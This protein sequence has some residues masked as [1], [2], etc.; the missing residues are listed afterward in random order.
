[1]AAIDEVSLRFAKLAVS[2]PRDVRQLVSRQ[3]STLT[4]EPPI[5]EIR[6]QRAE[7]NP[8]HECREP[9][10]PSA[11]ALW[12]EAPIRFH[13]DASPLQP[14]PPGPVLQGGSAVALAAPRVI[15]SFHPN[16]AGS[17]DQLSPPK[18]VA[19]LRTKVLITRKLM[20]KMPILSLLPLAPAL[21]IGSF[22]A[23][24]RAFSRIRRLER[25][26]NAP[27]AT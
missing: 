16:D 21:A 9:P 24:L 25:Q 8:P 3:R 13:I 23:V 20:K 22:V 18:E 6:A 19:M 14:S 5:A 27:A 1:M 2:K 15:R 4:T 12:S 11:D 7:P 26:I 10:R 17:A